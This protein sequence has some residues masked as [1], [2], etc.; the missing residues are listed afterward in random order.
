[1]L[2]KV[3]LTQ[4]STK[5]SKKSAQKE[6]AQKENAQRKLDCSL[7]NRERILSIFLSPRKVSFNFFQAKCFIIW[8]VS[9]FTIC[10][11]ISNAQFFSP[12]IFP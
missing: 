11:N 3:N 9:G 1:M 7:Y 10:G 8:D 5:K 4:K 6:N 12:R 2:K